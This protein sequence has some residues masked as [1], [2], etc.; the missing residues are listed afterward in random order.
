MTNLP[1]ATAEPVHRQD[2]VAKRHN[3]PP[4]AIYLEYSTIAREMRRL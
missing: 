1:T 4:R 2:D 3:Y